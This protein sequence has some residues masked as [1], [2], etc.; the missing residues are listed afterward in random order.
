MTDPLVEFR[1]ATD[2]LRARMLLVYPPLMR[3]AHAELAAGHYAAAEALFEIAIAHAPSVS[4][5]AEAVVGRNRARDLALQG[6]T[7]GRHC[8]HGVRVDARCFACRAGR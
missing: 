6:A 4:E 5:R 8:R 2:A 3:A 7:D 1:A